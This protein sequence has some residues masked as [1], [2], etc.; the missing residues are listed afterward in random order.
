MDGRIRYGPSGDVNPDQKEYEEMTGCSW[1]EQDAVD[2]W[3][4]E[5]NLSVTR[6]EASQLKDAVTGHRLKIQDAAQDLIAD[7]RK[8][9]PGEEL[10]CPHMRKLDELVN[11]K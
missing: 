3:I 4:K 6:M 10:L 11:P 9:Y 2:L 5:M 8:R 1:P 7:V